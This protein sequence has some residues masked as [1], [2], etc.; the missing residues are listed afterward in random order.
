MAKPM[1]SHCVKWT[2]EKIE[3][4][5]E[6]YIADH[7]LT[8]GFY[9]TD[10][11]KVVLRKI[12]RYL[13][14]HMR[15]LDLGCGTG[16]FIKV[17]YRK[18]YRVTGVDI[19]SRA[20]EHTRQALKQSGIVVPLFA[21]ALDRTPF[22]DKAFDI[23]FAFDVLEHSNYAYVINVLK[24]ARR[25]LSDRGIIITTMPYREK[26]STVVCPDCL[27]VFHPMGHVQSFDKPKAAGILQQAEFDPRHICVFPDIFLYPDDSFTKIIMKQ[28]IRMLFTRLLVKVRGHNLLCVGQKK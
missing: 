25:I 11:Y 27:A 14:P 18:G 12:K 26:L 16:T 4:M 13:M 20:I 6:S 5:W 19:S 28:V 21:S 1:K 9:P 17:F 3:A 22:E 15:C 7:N 23:V 10:F 24:E 2:P 8:T